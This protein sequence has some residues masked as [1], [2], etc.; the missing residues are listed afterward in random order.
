MT[1]QDKILQGTNFN[2]LSVDF[3]LF[4][5]SFFFFVEQNKGLEELGKVIAKQKQIGQTI[6]DEVDHQNGKLNL[7]LFILY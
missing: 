7:T 1:Q 4:P 6:S 3:M 2:M 5:L